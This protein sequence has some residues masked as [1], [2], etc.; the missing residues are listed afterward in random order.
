MYKT[1]LLGSQ[2]QQWGELSFLNL[3]L[4]CYF[5]LNKK[6]EFHLDLKSSCCDLLETAHF[7]K[8]EEGLVSRSIRWTIKGVGVG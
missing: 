8:V 4:L 2:D 1:L 3:L 6:R 7:L 5:I